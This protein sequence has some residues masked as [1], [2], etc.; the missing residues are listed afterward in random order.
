MKSSSFINL[1][2]NIS[3]AEIMPNN[4]F[5]ANKLKQ[6][7]GT[8]RSKIKITLL[9]SLKY[10]L[11]RGSKINFLFHVKS[12]MSYTTQ[13]ATERFFYNRNGTPCAFEIP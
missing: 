12:I 6:I 4:I 5:I 7:I 3:I 2:N 1:K 10:F 11:T 8:A 9:F 13:S